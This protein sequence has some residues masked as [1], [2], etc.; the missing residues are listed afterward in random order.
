MALKFT[1]HVVQS[2]IKGHRKS[3]VI[4]IKHSYSGIMFVF[5]LCLPHEFTYSTV[6]IHVPE[7]FTRMCTVK[8]DNVMRSASPHSSVKI[9]CH[10]NKNVSYFDVN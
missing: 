4:S 1:V 6:C 5:Y 10:F 8:T 9:T 2:F 3:G 7:I